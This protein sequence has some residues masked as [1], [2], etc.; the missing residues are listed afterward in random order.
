[1]KTF[2]YLVLGGGSGGIASARRA[3][4]YGAR[5][6]LIEAARL[7]GTCVNVGCVPKKIMF[8][9]ASLA[10]SFE[11]ADA[12]G[13][14]VGP[15]GFDF[16]ALVRTRNAHVAKLNEIY[17]QHL[18]AAGIE[19]IRGRGRFTGPRTV[20]VDGKAYSAE[21]VLIAVG[22][23]PRWP[24]VPGAELGISSDQFF[25]LTKQPRRIAIAGSGYVATELG[26]VLRA[27]GSDVTLI[28]RGDGLL[29]EFDPLLREV[30]HQEVESRGLRVLTHSEITHVE[31]EADG[32][33]SLRTFKEEK[34]T[35]FD[36]LLWAIGRDPNT[37]D[38]G[39]AAAGVDLSPAGHVLVNELQ[40]TSTEGVHAVGDVTGKWEFTP[41][42]IA[43]GRRLADRLCGGQPDAKLE[44]ES[45]PV[46]VFSHPPIGSVGLT[47]AQARAE[48]VGQVK[49][50]TTRFV[51]LF[52]AV[53][54]RRERTAMKLITV[55]PEERIVGLHVIGHGADEMLQGFAVAV[56]MGAR[57]ADFDRT[58]AIHPTAAEEFVTLR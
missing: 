18:D 54:A 55:G 8:N 30:L 49:V 16:A 58:I 27:L 34:L 51:N 21:H 37:A 17:A 5:V 20:E 13:F 12:Y 3:A 26:G 7:G 53:T 23:H 43:A 9:A 50:Y 57:K 4:S 39:L 11:V 28:A 29:R 2:D 48:Y 35:G 14:A 36:T 32:S 42:A 41:V 33:L 10:E 6:G 31:R 40:D 56:R 47:E 44:I 25:D 45:V 1:M 46:V 38:L 24:D 52:H 19:V 15:R 22:G